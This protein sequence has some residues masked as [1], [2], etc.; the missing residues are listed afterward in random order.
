MIGEFWNSVPPLQLLIGWNRC[1]EVKINR[2][3]PWGDADVHIYFA[4]FII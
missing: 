3:N 4:V 1:R 2:P